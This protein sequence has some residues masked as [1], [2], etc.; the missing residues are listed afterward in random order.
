VSGRSYGKA[1]DAVLAPHGFTRDGNEWART[2]GD[3]LEV[4]DLQV[5]NIAGVTAN[6]F[7]HDIETARIIS[8]IPSKE[9][10]FLVVGSM[11][12]GQLMDGYDRWWKRDP[13]GPAEL[14]EA[15]RVYGLPYFDRGV[16]TLEQQAALRYGRG[17]LK[18]WH[19]PSL[20]ALAVTLYRMGEIEEARAALRRP[21]PK[22]AI[23]SWVARVESVRRWLDDD[24]SSK[25]PSS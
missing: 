14:A 10:L 17:S 9:P 13:N 16:Q 7:Q 3:M 25:S 18:G 8:E 21:T 24:E 1:L 23:S 11:R 19:G 20:I 15:V 22:T 2:R 4:V 5:S 6:L 12:I